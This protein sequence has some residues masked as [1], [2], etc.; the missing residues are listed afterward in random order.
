ASGADA[1]TESSLPDVGSAAVDRR[2]PEDAPPTEDG[3]SADSGAVTDSASDTDAGALSD[4]AADAGDGSCGTVYLS[5]NFGGTAPGWTFDATWAVA[6]TCATPPAPQKGHPDPTVDHTTGAAGGVAGAYVCGN[7]P[8]GTTSP[9]AYATSPAVD[10]SAAPAVILT[11]YRWLNTDSAGWMTS[12]V[13]VFDGSTW[14][15]VYSNPNGSAGIVTDSAWTRVT[16]D[17]TAHKNAAFRV[18][19]GYSILDGGVY[20]MS[21]WNVD[22]VMLSSVACM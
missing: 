13:D 17:V 19:F 9:F 21:C 7:N 20:A 12:T 1:V 3:P 5:E 16:F 15:N 22:D 8:T 6:T 10:V 11:F 4:A 18:R 2:S 14:V